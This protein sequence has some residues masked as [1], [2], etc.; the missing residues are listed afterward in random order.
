MANT[1]NQNA[2]PHC[3]S[4]VIIR[5]SQVENPL[6]KTLYGQCQNLECGWTGKAHLE[7]AATISPSAIPNP[8]INIPVLL[9]AIPK[10]ATAHD[11]RQLRN[12]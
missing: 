8:A 5:H 4:K 6:L 3:G 1:R 11:S 10:T 7:W 9:C 12:R 2:C